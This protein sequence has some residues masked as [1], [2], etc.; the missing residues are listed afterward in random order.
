MDD[1]PFKPHPNL[2]DEINNNISRSEAEGGAYLNDLAD[3][4][5]LSVIT[6]HHIYIIEKRMGEFWIR[7]H[8][9]YCPVSVPCYINGSTWGGSMLKMKF[10]GIGMHMEFR[11]W[12]HPRF[13]LSGV[14]LDV[15]EEDIPNRNG[16][17]P[18]LDPV[19]NPE[20]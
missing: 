10:I 7:G 11:P 4:K 15:K 16:V 12:T 8:E 2:S 3:D 1:Q 13:L 5:R 14:I 9:M 18:K 20:M 6:K 17:E 19:E